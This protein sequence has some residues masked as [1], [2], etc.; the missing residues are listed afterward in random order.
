[1]I[2]VQQVLPLS[3]RQP[4]LLE[5]IAS[6]AILTAQPP[7]SCGMF[8]DAISALT[9]A[10]SVEGP[11]FGVMEG[12]SCLEAACN[13]VLRW[14]AMSGESHIT[15]VMLEHDVAAMVTQLVQ[16]EQH[17]LQAF[18][19]LAGTR[20]A[21]PGVLEGS[22]LFTAWQ[23]PRS[24]RCCHWQAAA[25]SSGGE[26]RHGCDDS[27]SFLSA[28]T[29]CPIPPTDALLEVTE[30]LAVDA[31]KSIGA[32][33]AAAWDES[34]W[35][36][37]SQA[38]PLLKLARFSARFSSTAWEGRA[39][40]LRLS[41]AATLN[42]LNTQAKG[43]PGAVRFKAAILKGMQLF[44]SMPRSE[45]EG[46]PVTYTVST[47]SRRYVPISG[48]VSNVLSQ[49][50][51]SAFMSLLND[52]GSLAQEA[53]AFCCD[54]ASTSDAGASL[55]FSHLKAAMTSST[56][57]PLQWRRCLNLLLH[58]RHIQRVAC[59]YSPNECAFLP[60]SAIRS[61]PM[62]HATAVAAHCN[63]CA[64]A[65]FSI[66]YSSPKVKFSRDAMQASNS[67]RLNEN[68]I[69]V[70]PC[71]PGGVYSWEFEVLDRADDI[72]MG[73]AVVH[74]GETLQPN[75]ISQSCILYSASLGLIMKD[76]RTIRSNRLLP[77]SPGQV[78]R[79]QVDLVEHAIKFN[80]VGFEG[81]TAVTDVLQPGDT[82][83]PFVRLG[84]NGAVR[85]SHV[86]VV[87]PEREATSS[88]SYPDTPPIALEPPSAVS[89]W[90]PLAWDEEEVCTT[91]GIG[92][93]WA[94]VTPIAPEALT[95]ET[96]ARLINQHYMYHVDWQ[97]K[98]GTPR[99][100]GLAPSGYF[101]S[102]SCTPLPSHAQRR[103][104]ALQ[105]SAAGA[106]PDLFR[107]AASWSS[108]RYS[109]KQRQPLLSQQ[110]LGEFVS[111][112]KT[113]LR[114][115]GFGRAFA[116]SRDGPVALGAVAA[117]MPLQEWSHFTP[118]TVRDNPELMLIEV[119]GHAS[120]QQGWLSPHALSEAQACGALDHL[121][122]CLQSL[123]N[124]PAR[125]SSLQVSP[126]VPFPPALPLVSQRRRSMVNTGI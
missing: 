90:T 98:R 83:F 9:A 116:C 63:D 120:A 36:S 104:I 35:R 51:P 64:T 15:K 65:C 97:V 77:L 87:G 61:S 95:E 60:M 20:V 8:H 103:P 89:C 17:P 121:L 12:G 99:S 58:E 100:Q 96:N 28:C 55:V 88:M 4:L 69:S 46:R 37:L 16:V 44:G 49:V 86:K 30:A 82:L 23:S 32:K 113:Y 70:T 42:H 101:L 119:L 112:L 74:E 3:T 19:S 26:Y 11:V 5:S 76:G 85:M 53:F 92:G 43:S 56:L 24:H 109:S 18:P 68:A 107:A 94:Q 114:I 108:S 57:T 73:C 21:S 62:S 7:T 27:R 2:Q 126:I 125:R 54:V 118:D 41:A 66:E 67:T 79:V 52:D 72:Q 71:L 45:V 78:L 124:L 105:A 111:A 93:N 34:V 50:V 117:V 29:Y 84:W 75:V 22:T 81:F 48:P 122:D 14:F 115:P 80:V 13:S 31:Q 40:Q 47:M 25:G 6:L 39:E 1:M 123:E 33:E 91:L 38:L 106:W 102:P 10:L 110:C 59:S